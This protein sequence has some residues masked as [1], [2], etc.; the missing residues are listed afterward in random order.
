MRIVEDD[1]SLYPEYVTDDHTNKVTG[2]DTESV[3]GH[4]NEQEAGHSVEKA[5]VLPAEDTAGFLGPLNYRHFKIIGW[6]LLVLHMIVPVVKLGMKF[7]PSMAAAFATPLSILEVLTPLSVFFLLIASMSQLISK[8]DYTKQMLI[9]GGAA[10]GV[11]SVYELI[12]HRYIVGTVDAFVGNRQATLA[13]INEVFSAANPAGFI[14]FNVF[15]DLFLCTAVM[16]FL[17][18]RPKRFFVGDRLKWFRCLTVLPVLYELVC[19][20]VKLLAN[21]GDFFMPLTVFP[22]LTAKPPM[23]FFVFCAMVVYQTTREARFCK[24][25]RTHEEYVAFIGTS[26]DCWQFARFSAIV[27][28]IAGILDLIIVLVA[29]FGDIS[30]HAELVTSLADDQFDLYATEVISKYMNAGFGGAADLLFFAPIM[31]LFNYRKTYRNTT[32]ELAIPLVSL[33]LLLV[34][35]LEAGL[36]GAEML[37]FMLNTEI[38]PQVGELLASPEAQGDSVSDEEIAALLEQL[39]EQLFA[40][41]GESASAA[42]LPQEAPAAVEPAVEGAP[43]AQQ[44]VA[45][46]GQPEQAT[47][48]LD[49]APAPGQ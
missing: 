21:S 16:F 45:Q 34:A 33:V 43:Q 39:L 5:I 20:W 7:D 27:C 32:V 13:M 1:A 38:M 14:A 25:G 22:F 6:L 35:Y 44:E 24:N 11:I 30:T 8:G 18:Y 41:E 4:H 10:L 36:M 29:F 15:L 47:P 2:F 48:A 28:A 26:E 23:M 3:I 9:N 19:L 46:P 17:N 40:D 12:Y 42:A 31:L 37:A 49:A